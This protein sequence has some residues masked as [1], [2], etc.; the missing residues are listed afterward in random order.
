MLVLYDARRSRNNK[1][2]K[3]YDIIGTVTKYSCDTKLKCYQ[4]LW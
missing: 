4:I 3:Y 1:F 2:V